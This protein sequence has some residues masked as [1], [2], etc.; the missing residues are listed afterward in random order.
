MRGVSSVHVCCECTI[1]LRT[2][3][4]PVHSLSAI[5]DNLNE[6]SLREAFFCADIVRAQCLASCSMLHLWQVCVNVVTMLDSDN[7]LLL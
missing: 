1:Y 3:K 4:P 7:P 5:S 2:L 6:Y